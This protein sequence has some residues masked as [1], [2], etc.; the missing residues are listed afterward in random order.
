MIEVVNLGKYFYTNGGKKVL[1]EG[2][3][4]VLKRLL[5]RVMSFTMVLDLRFSGITL[6][7]SLGIKI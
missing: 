1:F 7:L 6:F 2:V 3:S 4:F 5:Q